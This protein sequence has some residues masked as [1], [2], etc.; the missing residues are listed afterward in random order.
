MQKRFIILL[1]ALFLVI[2]LFV[3]AIAK[4]RGG[5]DVPDALKTPITLKYWRV[6]DQQDDFADIIARYRAL[7]PHVTIEYRQ[8]TYEE[9]E[10]ELLRGWAK[11]TGPDILSIQNSWVKKYVAE[12]FLAPLPPTTQ[13]AE[14]KVVKALGIRPEI[15]VTAPVK[16]SLTV[17]D[18]TNTFMDVVKTD[19]IADNA[20]Y[21]LPLSIDTLALYYN[22]KL[23]TEAKI[24][25]PA[26]GYTELYSEHLPRLKKESGT[27]EIL[28]SA[29]AMGTAE[30]VT[31]S[32]DILLLL[33]MQNLAQAGLPLTDARGN[34]NFL[35][36]SPVNAQ[37]LPAKNAFDFYTSFASPT[38]ESYTWNA[39]L[40]LS[41][42]AFVEG[43]VAYLFGYAYHKQQIEQLSNG[44]LDFGVAPFPQLGKEVNIA[45]YWVETVAAS[46][47]NSM[48]AWDF[49]EFAAREDNAITYLNRTKKPT[50]LKTLVET[51]KQDPFLSLFVDQALLAQS[52]YGGFAPRVAEQYV[53]EAITSVND[54]KATMDVAL[55][56]LN[57]QLLS[58]YSPP[59][60]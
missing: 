27:G 15:R 43:R 7:H 8:F 24:P 1:G 37:E 14:F 53:R 9:Y 12:G 55:E 60:L 28:Q 26:T 45:N 6:F 31:R 34:Y 29:I 16:P 4:G 42:N 5:T 36:P 30:N 41:L 3:I 49:V 46:S 58:T 39:T 19:V 54:G 56:L 50:A 2:L 40:P 17:A 23:L 47:P 13:V 48:T 59:S 25:L 33:M 21:G 44:T 20:I 35:A 18:I 32:Q 38:R 22:K 51:Q 11:G 57:R 52:W 10:D